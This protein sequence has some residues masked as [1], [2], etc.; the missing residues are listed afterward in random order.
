MSSSVDISYVMKEPSELLDKLL[1][2]AENIVGIPNKYHFFNFVITAAILSEW[3]LKHYKQVIPYDLRDVL[4]G[5]SNT[6]KLL[7]VEADNWIEDKSCLPNSA[8][9]AARHILNSIRIC[10]HTTNATKHYQWIKKDIDSIG[11]EAPINNFYDY[12]FTSVEESVF[13]R[14]KEENYTIVQIKDILIQ[15]YPKLIGYLESLTDNFTK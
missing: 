2:E 13:I 14:Y 5:K 7:M 9:G 8:Q 10:W 12:F 11:T 15:F 1:F 6:C 3:I 4:E